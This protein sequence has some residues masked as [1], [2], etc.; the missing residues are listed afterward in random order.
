MTPE[1][2]R[3][4]ISV[5]LSYWRSQIDDFSVFAGARDFTA[6][7]NSEIGRSKPSTIP[8]WRGLKIFSGA[9]DFKAT[10]S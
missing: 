1:Q 6:I 3:I 5:D 8:D 10:D 7:E 4:E 9:F 2:Q